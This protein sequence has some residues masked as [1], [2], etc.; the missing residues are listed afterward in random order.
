MSYELFGSF[1]LKKYIKL[2]AQSKNIAYLCIVIKKQN[3][4][5]N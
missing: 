4:H 3:S 1:F 5:E 2:F